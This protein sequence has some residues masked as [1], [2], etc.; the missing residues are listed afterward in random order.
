MLSALFS[1]VTLSQQIQLYNSTFNA[2]DPCQNNEVTLKNVYSSYS[3]NPNPVQ[4]HIQSPLFLEAKFY[5]VV[6]TSPTYL[7]EDSSFFV[8]HVDRGYDFT[9][10]P[11]YWLPIDGLYTRCEYSTFG[12][13]PYSYVTFTVPETGTYDL[14]VM[15]YN[16]TYR[17]SSGTGALLSA[18]PSWLGNSNATAYTACSKL[19]V[20]ISF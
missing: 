7:A 18:V 20:S 9:P 8:V 19:N 14:F 10:T 11:F 1:P 13:L 17:S 5:Y 12:S 16:D 3:N 6:V 15:S 4:P 2:N